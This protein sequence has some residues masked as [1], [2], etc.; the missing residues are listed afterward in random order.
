MK[1]LR[2]TTIE[3]TLREIAFG[4]CFRFPGTNT[5][6]YLKLQPESQCSFS[7][8]S[9]PCRYASIECGRVESAGP[10]T[11]V[12]PIEVELREL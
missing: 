11:L 8:A 3:V 10:G 4:D 2:K 5:M 9:S 6:A 7:P 12:I 1:F